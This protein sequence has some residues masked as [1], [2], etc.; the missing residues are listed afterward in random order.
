MVMWTVFKLLAFIGIKEPN[1]DEE[2]TA[3]VANKSSS[4]NDAV[5]TAVVAKGNADGDADGGNGVSL[6]NNPDEVNA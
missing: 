4:K 2:D 3:M 1:F 6:D 5:E